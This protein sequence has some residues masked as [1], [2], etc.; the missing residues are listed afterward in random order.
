MEETFVIKN[1]GQLRILS[2]P[3]RIRIIHL[4]REEPLTATQIAELLG[5]TPQKIY[6]HLV[7]LEK[8]GLVQMVE[9]RQKGNLVEKYYQAVAE[10]FIAD[11]AV[12]GTGGEGV[13]TYCQYLGHWV[14]VV[15]GSFREA[16]GNGT[17]LGEPACY[18]ANTG[19]RLQLTPQQADL[20]LE[21]IN[22]VID[23]FSNLNPEGPDNVFV[24]YL[25]WPLPQTKPRRS[26]DQPDDT[27]EES[28]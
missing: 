11:P 9:A 19:R 5:E 20:L 12:F 4:T 25:A 14:E 15:M 8:A 24:T 2:D 18:F 27:E 21:R 17:A 7:E 28:A 22:A 16:M 23:E 26:T 3:L 13:E 6:Y 1:V 10:A